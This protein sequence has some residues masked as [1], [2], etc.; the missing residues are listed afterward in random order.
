MLLSWRLPT[1][2]RLIQLSLL[3]NRVT[4]CPAYFAAEVYSFF[5]E[6]KLQKPLARRFN[7]VRQD[8]FVCV[9]EFLNGD[10][11]ALCEAGNYAVGF[12]PCEPRFFDDVFL[13]VFAFVG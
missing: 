3:S 12:E 1:R 11:A 8:D 13:E 5:Q 6:A 7:P 10:Y 4:P 2:Q 9:A